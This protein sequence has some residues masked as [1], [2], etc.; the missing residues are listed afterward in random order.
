MMKSFPVNP[1]FWGW[2]IRMMYI[3]FVKQS[4]ENVIPGDVAGLPINGILFTPD[5]RLMKR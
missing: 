1:Y 3:T 4:S 5:R 2:P